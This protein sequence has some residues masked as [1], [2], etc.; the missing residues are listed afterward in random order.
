MNK[1]M[2]GFKAVAFNVAATLSITIKNETLIIMTHGI[3]KM[4]VIYV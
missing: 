4:S 2:S 1:H 3:A